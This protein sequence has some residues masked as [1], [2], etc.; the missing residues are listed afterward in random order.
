MTREHVVSV[1]SLLNAANGLSLSVSL[2]KIKVYTVSLLV[3]EE[4]TVSSTRGPN[5]L[6]LGG[7]C[8]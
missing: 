8:S 4:V 6:T 7:A 3:S 5:D 2:C 1:C